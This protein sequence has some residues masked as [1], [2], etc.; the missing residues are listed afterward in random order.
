MSQARIIK[1]LFCR[2]KFESQRKTQDVKTY[3]KYQ[4]LQKIQEVKN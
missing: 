4:T 1:R 3:G 2:S